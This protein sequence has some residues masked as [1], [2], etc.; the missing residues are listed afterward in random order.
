LAVLLGFAESARVDPANRLAP[1]AVI[2]SYIRVLT[3]PV[4]FAYILVG[5]A[6]G[7]TVFGYVTGS[8]LFFVGAVGL[9]PDQYGLIFSACSAAVMSGALLDGRLGRRGIPAA[10]VLT[11]GLT[12]SAAAA[13]T[14]LAMTVAGWAQP[15][16]IAAL[17][18]AVALAFGMTM[19]NIM[20]ATMQPLP[21]IAGAVGAAAGSIQMTAGAASSGL[22]AVLFDGH[23]A[24]SMAA[25]MA[26]CSLVALI[27]YCLLARPAERRI[28]SHAVEAPAAIE[29][30]MHS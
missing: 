22:V 11:I 23:S 4:S 14:L 25:V 17:L 27:A 15:A 29:M 28:H 13:V 12:L 26:T 9:R 5:A 18:M 7:A 24:L 16:L 20:N 3:H 19:P 2:R 6:G 21:D 30:T 1:A 10:V 8:S